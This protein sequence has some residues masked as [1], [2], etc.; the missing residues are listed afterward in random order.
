MGPFVIKKDK[1]YE[2]DF[3]ANGVLAL[4]G[5]N[6]ERIR[7]L[8]ENDSSYRTDTSAEET[9][10]I[11]DLCKKYQS[12]GVLTNNER[13]KLI[14]SLVTSIDKANS[15]H[16]ASEGPGG[17]GNGR[18]KTAEY[19]SN[20]IENLEKRLEAGDP[21]LVDDIADKSIDGR[22]TFSFASKFCTYAA[23]ELYPGE[24]K[25]SIYD[26]V[27]RTALPYYSCV[28]L[29]EEMRL[30]RGR[31]IKD[32]YSKFGDK[33]FKNEDEWKYKRY[34]DLIGE[35]IKANKMKT[36]YEISRENFDNLLW[37]YFKGERS[38]IEKTRNCIS[39]EN[40]EESRKRFRDST[41]YGD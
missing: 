37:Y 25:Y 8:I 16:Q 40:R 15:T 21:S 17:G 14:K 41:N 31:C 36:G 6:V 28:Y 24:D 33:K 29:G 5:E 3:D 2:F 38:R 35:I 32:P 4:T 13:R 39:K 7:F 30:W 23:R 18:E 12:E 22:Y 11:K 20:K 34:S 9:K 1:P 26:K 19:I 27:V 10:D